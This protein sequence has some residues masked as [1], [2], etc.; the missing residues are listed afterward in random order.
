MKAVGVHQNEVVNLEVPVNPILSMLHV[1]I[2]KAV[3]SLID[4]RLMGDPYISDRFDDTKKG[5]TDE[6][7][8]KE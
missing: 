6:R 2:T 4:E 7:S 5:L 1:P 3:I 8:K